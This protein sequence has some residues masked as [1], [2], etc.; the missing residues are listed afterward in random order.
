MKVTHALFLFILSIGS[1]S[2]LAQEQA[3]D[4]PDWAYGFLEPL[5][6]GYLKAP[7]CPEKA[8]PRS[9]GPVGTPVPDDGIMRTLPGTSKS[10]TR[11]AAG[12]QWKPADWFPGDHPVMPKIVATGNKEAGVRPC[13]LCHFP[14]GRGKMENGHVAGLPSAYFLAQLDAFANGERY[15]ADPRKAN[16]N[17][18]A[19]IAHVLTDAE[20]IQAAEYF[21]SIKFRSI[22]RVVE[23]EEAPQVRLTLNSLML[24]VEDAPPM[25]LGQ[26]II[27]VPE[28]PELT[29]ALRYPR[30]TF[31]AYVP[32]G[33]IAKGEKLVTT[34]GD[35]TIPCSTCH[36]PLLQ[37]YEDVPAIAGRTASYTMRQLWDIK[38]GTRKS[39]LMTAIVADLSA[40]DMLNI[41]AYLATQTP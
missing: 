36:G 29:E 30:G 23:S 16:T 19:R 4:W 21:S 9:C 7:P 14:N 26:R 5:A 25:P 8:N 38:Q 41:V 3:A 39:P 6:P 24:P 40:Q 34:G 27:E 28:Y 17:E 10:F 32:T 15:S 22:M 18:M 11:N 1:E 12:D 31:I 2:L 20:K 37:G 13:S 33:S 35:K